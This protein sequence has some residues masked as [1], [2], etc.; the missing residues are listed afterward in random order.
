MFYKDNKVRYH[1]CHTGENSGWKM[2]HERKTNIATM[3]NELCFSEDKD[4]VCSHLQ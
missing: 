1:L 2:Q 4:Q 3:Q